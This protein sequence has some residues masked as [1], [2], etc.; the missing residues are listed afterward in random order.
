MTSFLGKRPQIQDACRK[1]HGLPARAGNEAFTHFLSGS[2]RHNFDLLTSHAMKTINQTK[3]STDRTK[4]CR[5]TIRSIVKSSLLICGSTIIFLYLQGCVPCYYAPSSQNVPLLQEQ[6]DFNLSGAFKVGSLTTGCEFQTAVAATDHLGVIANYSYYTGRQSMVDESKLSDSKSNMLEIGLGYYMPFGEKYV[7]ETYGGYGTA[8]IK[9]AH[10]SYQ[11]SMG[12]K[13]HSWSLFIQPSIGYHRP[14]AEM[15]FSTRLRMLDFNKLSF[16]S[17]QNGMPDDRLSYLVSMPMT[18]CVEP[19]FT[20]R[21]GGEMVKFQM[22]V[23]ISA[24]ITNI[25]YL[26]Y[27]PFNFNFGLIFNVHHKDK[28]NKAI[29]N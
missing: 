13:V 29:S 19:A 28:A 18:F 21:V 26:E 23:G 8:N 17:Y 15:A 2:W 22:Q 7:F 1:L 16:D 5:N 20:L 24:P 27:D 3:I 4:N 10:D 25:D 12:S 14:H 9:T 6:K 11:E